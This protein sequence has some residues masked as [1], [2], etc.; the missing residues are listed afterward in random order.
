MTDSDTHIDGRSLR[1]SSVYDHLW[2]H[3]PTP[4]TELPRTVS[5]NDKRRGVWIFRVH[6]RAS[7][8]NSDY[9]TGGKLVGIA[10]I[11]DRHSKESVVRTFCDTHPGFVDAKPEKSA[12][13]MLNRQGRQWH[14]AVREVVTDYWSD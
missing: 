12:I 14:D 10:Y 11:P 2:D 4:V 3:G 1:S 6:G 7:G 13:E 8:S 5:T 9:K